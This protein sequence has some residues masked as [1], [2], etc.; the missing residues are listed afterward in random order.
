[1]KKK[2]FYKLE[3][4]YRDEFDNRAMAYTEGLFPLGANKGGGRNSAWC[5]R[6]ACL[7]MKKES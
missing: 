2:S 6:E 7:K 4:L 5:S 1:M 3:G